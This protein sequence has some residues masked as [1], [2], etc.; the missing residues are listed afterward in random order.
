MA[1]DKKS[2]P[3]MFGEFCRDAGVLI[4][5]F[6]PLEAIV[7][8]GASSLTWAEIRNIVGLAGGLLIAGIAIERVRK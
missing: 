4:A 1:A 3:E 8:D 2:G 7:N 5:V 6:A